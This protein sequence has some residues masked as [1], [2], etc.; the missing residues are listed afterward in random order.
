[1]HEAPSSEVA[2]GYEQPQ[3]HRNWIAVAGCI[4]RD[5]WRHAVTSNRQAVMRVERCDD[6]LSEAA[7]EQGNES[8]EMC[9][10][11]SRDPNR[12]LKE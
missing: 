9:D 1:V 11:T 10:G 4:I 3:Y 12:W 5:V 7:D 8:N 2:E 6:C